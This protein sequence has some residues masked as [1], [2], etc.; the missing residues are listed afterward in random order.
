MDEKERLERM[1]APRSIVVIGA[2]REPVKIGHATLLNV[3]VSGYPGKVYPVNPNAHEIMGL[4]CYPSVLAIEDE[5]DLAVI[6]IPARFVPKVVRE[7]AVKG[8]AGV[9]IISAGFGEIGGEGKVLEDQLREIVKETGIRIIGPNTMGYK[10]PVDDLDASFVFGMPEAGRIALA[11]QSGALCI[12][13][14]HHAN[15]ERIGLSKVISVGNK[16]DVDDA[17]LIE[18]LNEDP[19]T[20]VIAMYIEGIKDGKKFMDAVR[21]C[22]K[23]IVAIKSGRTKAGAAAAATHTGSLSGSD[24]I[25]DSV[26]KQ[27][28]IHRARDTPELFDFATVLARQPPLKGKRIGIV[29]NGGGAGILL[30]DALEME[31][32]EVAEITEKTKERLRKVLPPISTPRNPVD[33]IG[34]AGFYLYESASKILLE[35]ENVDGIIVVCVHAGYARPKEYVG[36]LKKLVREHKNCG[37]PILGC[38]IGGEEMASVVLDLKKEKIPVYPST[39]RAAKAM[40]VLL[41]ERERLEKMKNERGK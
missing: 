35:D 20:K 13:M 5:I 26:F 23:P 33:V 3:L 9:I 11:S 18:Y 31:G 38:W 7:C 10:N 36:A 21:K 34:D 40:R 1:L 41:D 22:K 6:T 28:G 8:V 25:Y 27:L 17:E 12:G 14:I 4:K 30:S 29:T 16:I 24:K 37:K 2:S 39:T 15:R 32:L 19:H